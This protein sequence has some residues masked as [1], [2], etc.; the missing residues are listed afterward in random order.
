[1]YSECTE[2]FV[3][4]SEWVPIIMNINVTSVRNFER[5]VGLKVVWS[6]YSAEILLPR[7]IKA[8]TLAVVASSLSHFEL[9]HL[10]QTSSPKLKRHSTNKTQ[11]QSGDIF[12]INTQCHMSRV[13][14]LPARIFSDACRYK[15]CR[16]SYSQEIADH[17]Y[18][19]PALS[20]KSPI[21]FSLLVYSQNF[22]M[23]WESF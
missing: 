13:D 1:M 18:H 16:L 19:K 4:Q 21:S 2:T 5:I 7:A 3:C 11:G 8:S 14:H 17:L 15:G 22:G 23:Y 6:S 10:Q 20:I 12:L 9:R